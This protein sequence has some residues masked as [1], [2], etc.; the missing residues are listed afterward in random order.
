MN[1]EKQQRIGN[2]A[3]ILSGYAFDS[4]GFN[5]N[6]E[7]MPVIRIRDVIR[8]HTTTFYNGTYDERY[9]VEN[10]DILVGM[11]GEFNLGIWNGG[12]ALLN[13]RVCKITPKNGIADKNFLKHFLPFELKKIEDKTP[14]VTVKHLSTKKLAEIEIP[15][16]S[17]EEQKRIAAILDKADTIRRKRA[18]SLKLLDE[19]LRATFL[20]MF[21]DPLTNS[22]GWS[23]IELSEIISSLTS[24]SRGWA[25]HYSNEG[26][27]F[28]RI[29]NIGTNELLLND[30]AFVK[31]PKNAEAKRTRVKS[32]DILLSITADLGRTAVV[33]DDFG[34][35]YINQHLAKFSVEDA[36]PL[37]VS[38]YIAS[39]GGQTQIARKNKG[40]T[41]AGLNFDDIKSVKVPMP[42]MELQKNF[43]D[44]WHKTRVSKIHFLSHANESDTLFHSLIARAFKGG[45]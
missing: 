39:P 24:G 41:K 38:A 31:A 32:G 21:G 1:R 29:Q 35:G 5:T 37:F 45:L 20:D 43:A 14:F 10:G 42:P 28:L 19:L 17:R 22:K 13:Q 34:E 6:S 25:T 9:V 44:F 16:I 3:E 8:G 2:A 33:P 7:G 12:R 15:Q 36:E 40:G 27:K 11:D 18:E 23:I 26:A 30:I 4:N